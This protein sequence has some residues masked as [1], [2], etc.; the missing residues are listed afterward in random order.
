MHTTY[1]IETLADRWSPRTEPTLKVAAKGGGVI[2]GTMRVYTSNPVTVVRWGGRLFALPTETVEGAEEPHASTEELRAYYYQALV[3][4]PDPVPGT[5]ELGGGSVWP[6][7]NLFVP[8]VP[9]AAPEYP[10]PPPP[11]VTPWQ[12][13][14]GLLPWSR[15]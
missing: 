6:R 15:R 1:E 5:V 13:L 2:G 11:P 3:G 10:A 14:I 12:W 7:T 8:A 9:V 4:P